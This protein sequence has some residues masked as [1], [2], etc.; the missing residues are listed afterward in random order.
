MFSNLPTTGL[1]CGKNQS[2]AGKCDTGWYLYK[3]YACLGRPMLNTTTDDG[4]LSGICTHR[5]RITHLI[6]DSS[7]KSRLAQIKHKA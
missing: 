5:E 1:P 4:L 6:L 2:L 7:H 3:L